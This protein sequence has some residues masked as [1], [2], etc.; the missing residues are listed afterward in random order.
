MK[1]RTALFLFGGLCAAASITTANEPPI[2]DLD[3]TAAE[4]FSDGADLSGIQGMNAQS[5]WDAGDT[6]GAWSKVLDVVETGAPGVGAIRLR[7]VAT[8]GEAG[9]LR[10]DDGKYAPDVLL[11]LDYWALMPV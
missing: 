11:D 6:V 10:G 2:V 1:K 9:V 7:L 4:G 5:A 3:F 8:K